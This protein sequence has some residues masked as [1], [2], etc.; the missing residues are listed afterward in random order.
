LT[1]FSSLFF[2][3]DCPDCSAA[4]H[5]A[6]GDQR[7]RKLFEKCK[8]EMKHLGN[9]QERD[10]QAKQKADAE[11]RAWATA[12]KYANPSLVQMHARSQTLL[13]DDTGSCELKLKVCTMSNQHSFSL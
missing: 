11:D 2:Q 3:V 12:D 6:R 7:Q 4:L 9:K 8:N 13:L 5:Q 10:N 1:L